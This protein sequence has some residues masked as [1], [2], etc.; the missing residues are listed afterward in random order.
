MKITHCAVDYD[1][2]HLSARLLRLGAWTGENGSLLEAEVGIRYANHCYTTLSETPPPSGMWS[3][4]ERNVFRVFN[5][6]RHAL[7]VYLPDIIEAL[8]ARP[9]LQVQRVSDRHNFKIFQVGL[10]GLKRGE[11]YYVFFKLERSN[12]VG[13]GGIHQVRLSVES[14]YPRDN[15]VAGQW[16]PPFGKAIEEILGLRHEK[17]E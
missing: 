2:S 9:T 10:E 1:I 4:R 17:L 14:A 13:L 15:L 8:V 7:S 6:E 5:V 16:R 3:I 12:R 11:K